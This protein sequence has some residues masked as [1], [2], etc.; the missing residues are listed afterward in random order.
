M[1]RKRLGNSFIFQNDNDSKHIA[2]AVKAFL[3]RKAHSETLSVMD[4]PPQSPNLKIIEAVWDQKMANI[5]KRALN[6]L[7]EAS[8]RIPE[9]YS[10]KIQESCLREFRLSWRIDFHPR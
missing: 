6:V 5:K 2:N 8:R 3:D 4:W 1:G 9:D 7:Q 10:K